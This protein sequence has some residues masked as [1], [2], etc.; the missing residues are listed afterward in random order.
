MNAVL[1]WFFALPLSA[2]I[3]LSVLFAALIATAGV[4][5]YFL[6]LSV[7]S[8]AG[9]TNDGEIAATESSPQPSHKEVV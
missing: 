8:G 1:D 3:A 2:L 5:L 7:L 6:T 9:E 4:T